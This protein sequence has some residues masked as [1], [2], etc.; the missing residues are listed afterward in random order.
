[1]EPLWENW[2]WYLVMIQIYR[3]IAD[4]V[5]SG[6]HQTTNFTYLG[7][8]KEALS[9]L[10]KFEAPDPAEWCPR[11]YAIVQVDARGCYDSQG[12]IFVFGCQV[13]TFSNPITIL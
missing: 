9:G 8:H 1:M 2:K 4:E 10:E 13:H 12:D 6:S 3:W 5:I 7:V 11:G